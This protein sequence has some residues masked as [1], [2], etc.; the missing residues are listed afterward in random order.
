M[1]ATNDP[2]SRL[3]W[4]VM[5]DPKFDGIREDCRLF[6]AWSLMLVV[7]DMAWPAPAYIPPHVPRA[8]VARLATVELIDLLSGNRFRIHGLDAER[9]KRSHSARNAAAS[10]WQSVRTPTRDADPMLDETETRQRRAEAPQ[11]RPIAETFIR[12]GLLHVTP[13]VQ[14]AWLDAAGLTLLG[15]GRF[16]QDTIDDSCRRHP[17]SKVIAAILEA[18]DSFTHIP[19]AAALAGAVRNRLDPFQDTKV[20]KAQESERREADAGRRRVQATKRRNH[21]IGFHAD[22]P[23]PGCDACSGNAA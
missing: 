15:S 2:Y 7:A 18:R 20:T 21:E 23:D 1:S 11:P 6:G 5:D 8:A 10:R 16:A 3:Y 4:S 14:D 17:E 12:D 9:E 19:A 22:E 13:L